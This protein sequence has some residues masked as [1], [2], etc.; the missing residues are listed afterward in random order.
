MRRAFSVF[1]ALLALSGCYREQR[2]VKGPVV[3]S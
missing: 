1:A 3:Q 2:P